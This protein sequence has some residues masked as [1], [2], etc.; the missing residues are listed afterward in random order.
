LFRLIQSNSIE[1]LAGAL[2]QELRE[3]TPADPFCAQKVLVSTNAM[4]R[5][6]AL[7]LS[8][9]LGICAGIDFD[10]G[11][12]HLRKLLKDLAQQPNHCPD[13][14]DPIS[15]RWRIA[16]LIPR[17]PQ[18]SIWEPLRLYLPE[19]QIQNLNRQQIQFLLQLADTFD[20]YGLYRPSVIRRWLGGEDLDFQGEPLRIDQL[21][22]PQLMRELHQQAKTLGFDHPSERLDQLPQRLSKAKQL[23]KEWQSQGPLQVFG[24]S[25]LPPAFLQMLAIIASHGEREVVL[26]LLSPCDHPWGEIIPALDSKSDVLEQLENKLLHDGHPLLAN[27]GRTLRDF[28]WQL[29]KIAAELEENFQKRSITTTVEKKSITLLDQLKFDLGTGRRRSQLSGQGEPLSISPDQVNLQIIHCHGDRRQVEEAHEAVLALMARDPSL[30]S[31]QVLLLTTDVARFAP[32]V[33][34]TFERPAGAS[35]PRHLPIR[36]TDRTLRQRNPQIDL[37]FRLLALAGS[38]YELEAVLD[39]LLLPI[40]A[41]AMQLTELEHHQ[42]LQLIESV[43][44]TWGKDAQHRELWGY[45]PCPE[46]SW[47]WGLDRL[48]LGIFLEDPFPLGDPA[49][50]EWQGLAAHAD[51]LLSPNLV[52]AL[53][54]ACELLFRL[55]KPLEGQLSPK[56]WAI[57]LV[58]AVQGMNGTASPDGWQAPELFELLSPLRSAPEMAPTLSRDAVLLLLEKAEAK[59]QGRYGHVSGAVTLS[60]L[61]PM[62]S[63]PHRVVVLLGMDEER[64][65]RPDQLTEYNLM[66]HQPWRGDRSKRMEDR[67]ILLETLLAC[68]DHWIA[69]YTGTDPRTGEAR[70][71]ASPLADLLSCIATEYRSTTENPL[72]HYLLHQAPPLRPIP[73]APNLAPEPIWPASLT[74][75][76]TQIETSTADNNS[77]SY[78][79]AELQQFF[80]DPARAL[81]R[82]HGIQLQ[83]QPSQPVDP[84]ETE[85]DGLKQWQLGEQ[86]LSFGPSAFNL[87]A[88][89]RRAML[90]TGPAASL[91]SADLIQRSLALLEIEKQIE[92]SH[93]DGLRI[94]SSG[95]LKP[96][97]LLQGWIAHLF[98]NQI[99]PR[100]THLIGAKGSGENE[101]LLAI[102]LLP[103]EQITA[104]QHLKL[105]GQLHKEG[106]RKLLI[107][108]PQLSWWLMEE[109]RNPGG[110]KGEIARMVWPDSLIQLNGGELPDLETWWAQPEC[111]SLAEQILLPLD[112]AI[113][114]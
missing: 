77:D 9:E 19:Q 10:F 96:K 47:Q 59:E 60:A 109:K 98:A 14:W 25:S 16:Q 81:L 72:T 28:N 27:L 34:A 106:L 2:A 6:L 67:A 79:Q 113:A 53:I 3:H 111:W 8:E 73:P 108:D 17:L 62:R 104:K 110:N 86:L 99:F 88:L 13:P 94:K 68:R 37:L 21:W 7:A 29:E 97:R 31:R 74:W 30:Q 33:L 26:Y 114:T 51:P 4:G 46:N 103:L 35:D 83:R 76:P 22:Q 12:A 90:P 70:N 107:F 84:E 32:L 64:L 92:T 63:I 101:K 1:S 43:G 24:L 80:D 55:L 45:P 100:H 42:W 49:E 41:E 44:I 56:E 20:Q 58:E 71:P 89:T 52:L 50:G 57:S 18:T 93:P 95:K 78:A 40:V 87:D 5:W 82:A 105:L 48:L 66:G 38:R 69:T 91:A 23:Q 54:K 65:P 85:L 11:G 15:L 39:L 36:V 112:A 75:P 102:Q 61:E